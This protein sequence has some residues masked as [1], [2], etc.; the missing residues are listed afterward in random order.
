MPWVM[1]VDSSATIALP[2]ESALAASDE[3]SRRAFAVMLATPREIRE[4]GSKAE[5]AG[6]EAR[7]DP[8]PALAGGLANRFRKP[9]LSSG[10]R[11]TPVKNGRGA[12][13]PSSEVFPLASRSDKL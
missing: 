6:R 12:R 13:R 4:R 8:L 9:G 7:R 10:V 2:C 1:I 3:R 5:I 11:R